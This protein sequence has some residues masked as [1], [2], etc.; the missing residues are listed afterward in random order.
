MFILGLLKYCSMRNT[1]EKVKASMTQ[2]CLLWATSEP[3]AVRW[4]DTSEEELEGIAALKKKRGRSQ[5]KNM[6][7][8]PCRVCLIFLFYPSSW[9]LSMTGT[10]ASASPCHTEGD[11]PI[12]ALCFPS[13]F[14]FMNFF[15]I[16]N[17]DAKLTWRMPYSYWRL[18]ENSI[19][20]IF[21]GS[22]SRAEFPKIMRAD[23]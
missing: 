13:Y 20:W 23:Y 5:R 7:C 18:K 14:N 21:R 22:F 10:S 8:F 9:Y 19:P 4:W 1:G 16:R 11:W 2:Y 3:D 6:W 15:R 17:Y 12:L